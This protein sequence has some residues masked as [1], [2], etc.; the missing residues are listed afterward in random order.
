MTDATSGDPTEV[1]SY[2]TKV[3]VQPDGRVLFGLEGEFRTL[4]YNGSVRRRSR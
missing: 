3:L 2:A 1:L 4:L